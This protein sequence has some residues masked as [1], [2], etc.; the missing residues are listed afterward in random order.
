MSSSSEYS[1]VPF[2][3]G[4]DLAKAVQ[5]LGQAVRT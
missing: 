3:R 5:T 4:K 2:E 1:R